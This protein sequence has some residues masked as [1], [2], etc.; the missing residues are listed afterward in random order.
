MR[1]SGLAAMLGGALYALFMFFHPPNEPAGMDDA[2]WMPVHVVWL[3]SV[4]LILLGLVGLY[5]GH[6]PIGWGRWG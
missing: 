5:V 4:L 1:W 2:L 6:T 3:V